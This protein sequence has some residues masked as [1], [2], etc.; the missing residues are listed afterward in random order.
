M[1]ICKDGFYE[2]D[3]SETT[4]PKYLRDVNFYS[5]EQDRDDSEGHFW[6]PLLI[7]K[8]PKYSISITLTKTVVL[9]HTEIEQLFIHSNKYTHAHFFCI[10]CRV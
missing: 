5:C 3:T 9:A 7:E 8:K 4:T 2:I 10:K 6:I 1:S